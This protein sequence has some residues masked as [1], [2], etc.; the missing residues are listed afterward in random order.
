MEDSSEEQNP[1]VIPIQSHGMVDTDTAGL[2]DSQLMAAAFNNT[3]TQLAQCEELLVKHGSTL[4]NEYPRVQKD[5]NL[6]YVGPIESPNHLLGAFPVLFPYGRGGFEVHREIKVSYEKHVRWALLYADRR[7]RLDLQFI[8]QV[9]GVIVKRQVYTSTLVQI[10]RS[11]YKKH[12][13]SIRKL[14]AADFVTASQEEAKNL[15]FSNP[16]IRIFRKQLAALR[17]HVMGTDE[18]RR[19]IRS[20]IW[21]CT[22]AN[23]PPSLW[24]TI[25][26]S[27][28][29]DPIVQV[30]AGEDID[31]DNFVWQDGP[32]PST[33][34]QNAAADPFAASEFFH[35][36]IKV[37]LEHLFG[38]Y[39][40]NKK[41]TLGRLRRKEG[42][43]GTLKS[44]VGTVEAQGRGMLHLHILLWLAH[45][46]TS[47][48]MSDALSAEAFRHK[49]RRWIAQNITADIGGLSA[50][51]IEQL[52]KNSSCSYS[53]PIDPRQPDF[54]DRAA[55]SIKTL[56]RSL[57]VHSCKGHGCLR[58]R[59][60]VEQCKRGAPFARS[61]HSWVAETGEWGP[62]RIH[63]M[64][65]AFN[66]TLMLCVRCNHDI[67]LLTNVA[68]TGGIAWYITL[69]ATKK[70]QKSS[71][72]SAVL[73]RQLAFHSQQSL[74]DPQVDE[75]N[76]KMLNRCANALSRDQEFSAPEVIGY[77]MGWGDRYI[78][79]HYSVIYW[80]S[81][82][83][84]LKHTFPELCNQTYA[85]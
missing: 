62:T 50:E 8:F 83:I 17:T 76:Q 37:I 54:A 40:E 35:T 6:R 78:S 84:G 10:K 53:R 73:A 58:F 22:L 60:G 2:S 25:N 30:L 42:I 77:L 20:Q 56:A 69:Y 75:L 71:N 16:T 5:M 85:K 9:F 39:S 59:K 66:N 31:L 24:L 52:P 47:Q 43:L 3:A 36:T 26:P 41:N 38:L 34:A 64:A 4:V 45:A 65:V 48:E 7:F 11:T 49:V 15:P 72:A 29:H 23:G 19:T 80:D 67:K 74:R 81:V 44:Y 18:S 70:Q 21:G 13:E 14:R 63:Q 55:A 61:A 12:A 46:P 33:R 28:V 27:D 51:A 57:Q 1:K 68:S 32:D 79:N 82:V